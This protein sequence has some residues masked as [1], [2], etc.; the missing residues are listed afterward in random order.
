MREG[1]ERSNILE[2]VAMWNTGGAL[3]DHKVR[4]GKWKTACLRVALM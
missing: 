3:A 2:K 1:K 4:D